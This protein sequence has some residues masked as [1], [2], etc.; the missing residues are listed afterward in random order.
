MM[1]GRV[2]G[3][4]QRGGT[5]FSRTEALADLAELM[6]VSRR[7]L[8]VRTSWSGCVLTLPVTACAS[9]QTDGGS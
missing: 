9:R 5:F 4:R 8:E 1:V 2:G 6:H 3:E 7:R